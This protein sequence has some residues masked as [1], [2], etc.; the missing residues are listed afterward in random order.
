MLVIS[1][2]AALAAI[3]FAASVNHS[4]NA[5]I[6]PL[7]LKKKKN[8]YSAKYQGGSEKGRFTFPLL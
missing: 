8:R 3:Y 1:P 2:H 4:A 5:T 7:I 6:L